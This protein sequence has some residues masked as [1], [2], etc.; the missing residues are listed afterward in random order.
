M[1]SWSDEVDSPD[2]DKVEG[3][4]GGWKAEV[5]SKN[6]LLSQGALFD[7]RLVFSDAV[8]GG[9]AGS[10]IVI[11]GKIVDVEGIDWS[12]EGGVEG[13]DDDPTGEVTGLAFWGV[14]LFSRFFFGILPRF[15][16]GLR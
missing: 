14:L 9:A 7:P 13:G 1:D 3:V 6:W 4:L 10:V 16:R 2:V 15:L 5:D 11:V 12:D 8:A